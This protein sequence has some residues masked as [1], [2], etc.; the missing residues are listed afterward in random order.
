MGHTI[1]VIAY[2]VITRQEPYQELGANCFAERNQQRVERQL[3]RRLERLGYRVDLKLC[4]EPTEAERPTAD[5]L[6]A[7]A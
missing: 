4:A 5:Q 2:H 6:L 1:L 7:A 3:V